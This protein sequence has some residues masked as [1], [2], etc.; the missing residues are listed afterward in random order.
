MDRLLFG[1][2][3][4]KTPKMNPDIAEGLAYKEIR[5]CPLYI[6]SYIDLIMERM[7]PEMK[8]LGIESCRPE[9]LFRELVRR[10]HRNR[11]NYDIS[12]SDLYAIEMKFEWN[13]VPFSHTILVP[14]CHRGGVMRLSGSIFQIKPVIAN[15]VISVSRDKVIVSFARNTSTF[16]REVHSILHNGRYEQRFVVSC[17]LH[18]KHN[19][20]DD[21][22]TPVYRVLSTMGL[23][24]LT[25]YGFSGM[26][27]KVTN[28]EV[29]VGDPDKVNEDI[30]PPEKYSIFST[31]ITGTP[32]KGVPMAGYMPTQLR[33]AVPTNSLSPEL[34][35]LIHEVFY[36]LDCFPE[37]TADYSEFDD[38]ALWRLVL[39]KVI[40]SGLGNVGRNLEDI[41][42]HLSSI[43]G[44]VDMSVIKDLEDAG[45]DIGNTYEFLLYMITNITSYLTSENSSSAMYDR[46]LTVNRYLLSSV[47][48]GLFKFMFKIEE[49]VRKG[50]VLDAEKVRSLLAMDVKT[51]DILT[52]RKQSH[53]EVES[54]DAASDNMIPKLTS[55]LAL[56]SNI[57]G[58]GKKQK[59][60]A[61]SE[62]FKLD[63]SLA[64]VNS[65]I[66]LP[67]SMSSGHE[68]VSMFLKLTPKG[69][70]VVNHP[71]LLNKAAK[72]LGQ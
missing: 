69:S 13:S 71:S 45:L 37:V 33:I 43:E 32:P 62:E 40:F 3:E 34:Y 47:R 7:P 5:K 25:A 49:M 54:I 36:V 41:R 16:E 11:Q 67:K 66:D 39:S 6:E 53:A 10:D 44:Y 50:A 12:H 61:N 22:Q 30:F 31:A 42:T 65:C 57:G 28:A 52:I 46:Q 20:P 14:Y 23:Y 48:H 19:K 1:M 63:P 4:E 18:H 60:N 55:K 2:L 68:K 59:I 26:F 21:G 17:S 51:K 27:K 72:E 9:Q 29:V 58:S 8:F 70:V 15:R 24:L 35:G 38:P 64:L 56:Q